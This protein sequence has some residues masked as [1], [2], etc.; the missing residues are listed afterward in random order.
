VPEGV[1][2]PAIV[3]RL[4]LAGGWTLAVLTVLLVWFGTYPSF[5]LRAIQTAVQS[6][7]A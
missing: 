7:M 1:E 2:A 4:S 6:L 5:I 3:S